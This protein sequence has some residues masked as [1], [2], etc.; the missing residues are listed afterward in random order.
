M[1]VPPETIVNM[2]EAKTHL[3]SLV[4]RALKGERIVVAK[5]GKPQVALTPVTERPK[6][7]QLG[8][9]RGKIFIGENFDD[10]LPEFEEY[11]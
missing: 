11:M 2:H 9:D 6:R 10:P 3:S 5:N 1:A 8:L 7:R 4:E